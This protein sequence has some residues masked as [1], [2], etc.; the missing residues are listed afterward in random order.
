MLRSE[1]FLSCPLVSDGIP[2]D[3]EIINLVADQEGQGIQKQNA[4]S[5][6]ARR[7]DHVLKTAFKQRDCG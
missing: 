2:S 6:S 4:A 7:N 1:D 3:I 5:R